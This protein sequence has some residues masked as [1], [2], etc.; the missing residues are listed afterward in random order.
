MNKIPN[1]SYIFFDG[2]CNLCNGF[3]QFVITRDKQEKF[4]F[5]SL[6][7]QAAEK[8]LKPFDFPLDELKTIILL[9]DGKIYLRSRAVLRIASQLGGSWKLSALLYVFPSFLSDAVYNLVSKYRYKLF[10]KR[11]SCMIPSPELKSR[12]IE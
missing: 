2:V 3:V 7:S 4:K 1:Q 5:S 6:Q 12:L 9:Q 8:M 11:D 10:G